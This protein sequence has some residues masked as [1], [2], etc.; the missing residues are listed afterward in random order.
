MAD[1][2]AKQIAVEAKAHQEQIRIEEMS[3]DEYDALPLQEKQK[4]EKVR[5]AKRIEKYHRE[6]KEAEDRRRETELMLDLNIDKKDKKKKDKDGGKIR[7][8]LE[9][10]MLEKGFYA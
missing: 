8:F 6:I 1:A 9:I 10:L 4:I 2:M 7:K 3:E 5:L